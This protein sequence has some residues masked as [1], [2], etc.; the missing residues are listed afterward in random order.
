MC[1]NLCVIGRN[2][3]SLIPASS[4]DLPTIPCATPPSD[5]SADAAVTG[6]KPKDVVQGQTWAEDFQ[7]RSRTEKSHNCIRVEKDVTE[8]IVGWVFEQLLADP[9]AEVRTFADGRSWNA[10]GE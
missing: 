2:K 6:D 10:G 3:H 9:A 5:I 8:R 7:V 4:G 1:K